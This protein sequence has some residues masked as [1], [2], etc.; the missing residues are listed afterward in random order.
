[1]LIVKIKFSH[2]AKR[3]SKLYQI[4]EEKILKIVKER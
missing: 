2:H 1:M 4:P 3:R